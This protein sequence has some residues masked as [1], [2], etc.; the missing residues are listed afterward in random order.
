LCGEDAHRA[1]VVVGGH[2]RPHQRGL[3]GELRDALA[4]DVWL[5]LNQLHSMAVKGNRGAG[6]G[7]GEELSKRSSRSRPTAPML[8][9]A[10]ARALSER[11]AKERRSTR[12]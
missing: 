9:L 4:L 12:L 1:R 10:I 11:K 8:A 5:F 6:H 2:A 7:R 3:A